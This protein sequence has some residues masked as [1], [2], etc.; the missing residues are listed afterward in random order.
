M[1]FDTSV[2]FGKTY[3]ERYD[4]RSGKVIKDEA[5]IA[6][7]MCKTYDLS[8]ERKVELFGRADADSHMI[9]HLG[10]KLE[11]TWVEI[12]G[13]RFRILDSRQVMG[14]ATYMIGEMSS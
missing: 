4:S 12:N 1:R 9:Y 6:K 14:K 11:A 7:K 2:I 13:I 5:I 10:T 3:E 8:T